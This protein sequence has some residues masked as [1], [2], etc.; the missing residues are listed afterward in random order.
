MSLAMPHVKVADG[1][2][3]IEL[4]E[5]ET[6][7]I[8]EKALTITERAQAVQITD[9]PTYD[10]AVELLRGVK[11]L[12][13]EAEAHHRPMIEAAYRAHK[14]ATDALKRIDDPLKQAE[15]HVKG[16]IGAWDME[17][18]RIRREAQ[19]RLEAEARRKAEEEALAAAIAAEQAGASG[20][21]VD[22]VIE[23][24]QYAP[25]VA[26][27]PPPVYEK[28]SGV[29]TRTTYTPEVTNPSELVRHIAAHPELTYL[30]SVNMPALR[31]MV[32]AQGAQFRL[33]GVRVVETKN[34]AVRS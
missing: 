34:V 3:Q 6:K 23:E 31:S 27:P 1:T 24:A 7:Q 2:L 18:E 15:S 20:A 30:L 33:P 5:P 10:G 28:A 4:V 16:R 9:Q 17:Q 32:K 13:K 12:R 29:V 19:Q 25:V 26:P 14:A 8:E 21:E 11:A 22:A